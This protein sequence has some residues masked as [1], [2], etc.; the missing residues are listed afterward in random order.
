MDVAEPEDEEQ[1]HKMEIEQQQGQDKQGQQGQQGS[2]N[3]DIMPSV[4]ERAEKGNECAREEGGGVQTKP[5]LLYDSCSSLIGGPQEVGNVNGSSITSGARGGGRGNLSSR[6]C[7]LSYNSWNTSAFQESFLQQN[8]EIEEAMQELK[9]HN[10]VADGMTTGAEGAVEAGVEVKEGAEG[11]EGK[12]VVASTGVGGGVPRRWQKGE[13]LGVGA[14]G[15]VFLAMNQET[16]EF[17]AVKELAI[18][19]SGEVVPRRLVEVEGEGG[20]GGDDNGANGD[21]AGANSSSSSSSSS[22]GT[23]LSLV[24]TSTLRPAA[25]VS[26][27]AGNGVEILERELD[28]LRS[29]RHPNI[30]LYIG[31]ARDQAVDAPD[32]VDVPHG[33][34]TTTSVFTVFMEFVPGGSIASL[35]QRFRLEEVTVRH[36]TAGLLCGLAF[37]HERGVVHGDVKAANVLVATNG[38][39]KVGV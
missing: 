28:F 24:P 6:P 34:V 8:Q 13:A 1:A 10:D 11:K 31:T 5:Q 22:C 15:S 35:S 20:A 16:G 9:Q 4:D 29:L 26:T 18:D 32:G 12:G 37:L 25:A 30:V 14:F 19:T 21:G 36:Y 39:V 2:D 3:E 17:M 7:M 27:S 33:R 23:L 38:T